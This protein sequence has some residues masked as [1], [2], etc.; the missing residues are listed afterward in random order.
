MLNVTGQAC[1]GEC[2]AGGID[3]GER[4][5]H[6]RPGQ[7]VECGTCEP[8]LPGGGDVSAKTTSPSPG[9]QSTAKNASFSDPPEGVSKT[10]PLPDHLVMP[11]AASPAGLRAHRSRMPAARPVP[12]DGQVTGTGACRQ[13]GQAGDVQPAPTGRRG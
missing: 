12:P 9:A 11:P 13:L 8:G 1:A 3:Q 5:L 2:P 7:R 4:M 6:T 10:R